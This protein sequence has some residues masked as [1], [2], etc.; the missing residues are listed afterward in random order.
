MHLLQ[1]YPETIADGEGI[2]YAIYLSGCIHHCKNCHNPNSWNPKAGAPLTDDII[3]NIIKDIN[4]NPLLDGITFSGGDPFYHP[5]DFFKL[6]KRFKE[7]TGLSIWCYTGYTFEELKE[8]PSMK[9][10]LPYID[11]LVD[12]KYIDSLH[13]PFISFRGSTNQRILKLKK[14]EVLKE[15]TD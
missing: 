4:N 12:G 5:A 10:I 6:I 2:R 11:V 13:S 15:I 9:I 1:T 8:N 3:S 14:G 7:E